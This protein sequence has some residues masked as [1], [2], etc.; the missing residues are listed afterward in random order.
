MPGSPSVRSLTR[1]DLAD[2]AA[3]H[4]EAFPSSVL[5][6]LGEAAI[7]RYYDWQLTGPHDCVAL[8]G[9]T[10]GQLVGFVFGGTF[11]AALFGFLRR[12]RTFLIGRLLRRPQLLAD[13]EL[14]PSIGMG[15]QSIVRRGAKPVGPVVERPPSF[16]I[17]SIAARPSAQGSGIAQQL[18][19]EAEQAARSRG[20]EHMNLTVDLANGRAIRF[21]ERNGWIRDHS[22]TV[23]WSGT[24]RKVLPAR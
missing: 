11:D 2:V 4:M 9:W 23:P 24:M 5:T 14:R 12:D 6:K 21:Y 13:P 22:L 7:R 16:G 17:L 15:L 20:F 8:G 10:G 18:L 3:V 1:G 19:A